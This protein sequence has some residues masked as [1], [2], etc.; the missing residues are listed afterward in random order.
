MRVHLQR[1]PPASRELGN[2]TFS[3]FPSLPDGP[4]PCP[5]PASSPY[6][7]T[8]AG[9]RALPLDPPRDPDPR[10]CRRRQE[11]LARL[12]VFLAPLEPLRPPPTPHLACPGPR[13]GRAP[14][15]CPPLWR[16][17]LSQQVLGLAPERAHRLSLCVAAPRRALILGLWPLLTA[18]A[19]P[20]RSCY[21]PHIGRIVLPP[22]QAGPARGGTRTGP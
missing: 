11:R 7:S 6:R 21:L 12:A 20:P 3:S 13:G 10:S 8:S 1:L 2:Q 16:G 15:G 17:G 14:A 18:L 22:K 5:C 19:F 4:V 9:L